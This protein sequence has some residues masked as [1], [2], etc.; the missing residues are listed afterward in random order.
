M[1]LPTSKPP[2]YLSFFDNTKLLG[3]RPR[4]EVSD[5]HIL[6]QTPYSC[7]SI[8]P[9]ITHLVP[10]PQIPAPLHHQKNT[11]FPVNGHLKHEVLTMLAEGLQGDWGPLPTA[12]VPVKNFLKCP[13][14]RVII[15]LFAG[16]FHRIPQFQGPSKITRPI[17]LIH[18]T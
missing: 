8:H 4:N 16:Q 14:W 10:A 18:Q 13:G 17:K 3:K 15:R 6:S 5:S 12:G 2:F 7:F 9:T 1:I 11:S